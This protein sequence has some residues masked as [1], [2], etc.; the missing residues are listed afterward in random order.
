MPDFSPSPR[1]DT[2]A[3]SA[4]AA[5]LA[6]ARS[7]MAALDLPSAAAAQAAP[8]VHR[9]L[10]RRQGGWRG[11]GVLA[12]AGWPHSWRRWSNA[13]AKFPTYGKHKDNS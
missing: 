13:A 5:R 9:S 3:G 2:A 6:E 7:R 1:R 8:A 10:R 4:L 11:R 12:S